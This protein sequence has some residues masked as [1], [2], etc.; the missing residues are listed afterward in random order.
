MPSMR[1]SVRLL[2]GAFA[3]ALFACEGASPDADV[4]AADPVVAQQSAA[5]TLQ[6]LKSVTPT[7]PNPWL[8]LLP[9][10]VKPDYDYWSTYKRAQ[11]A[12]RGVSTVRAAAV[13]QVA[14]SESES[15]NTQGTADPVAG[16]GTA[17]ADPVA[18]L[19]GAIGSAT[20]VDFFSF[21]LRAGDVIS[22]AVASAR[23]LELRAPNGTLLVG[24][25]Q[26]LSFL[27]PP[28]SPLLGNRSSNAGAALAYVV[29]AAGTYALAVRGATGSYA[30]D[31]QVHRPTL[32]ASGTQVVF[33][34]FDG[35]DVDP[36]IFDGP[37]GTRSL[38]PLA[39][40]LPA[41]GLTAAD[42]DAVITAIVNS[43][44]ENLS[45]DL[46]A[47]GLNP[48]AAIDLR[49][50]RD[51]LDP[52]TDAHVSRIIVG[53]TIPE[54]GLET[55]GVAQS[56]DPG[57]FG[58]QETAVV[59]LDILTG[60][61]GQSPLLS[62]LPRASGVSLISLVGTAVGNIVAHEAGHYLGN[63]HTDN[64]NSVANI[65]DQG[66]Y[67][68]N[69][70][71]LGPDGIFGSADDLDVDLGVDTYVPDEE[72]TGAE[73]TL[74]ITAFGSSGQAN[75]GRF[76]FRPSAV[77]NSTLR[78]E[79]RDANLAASSASVTLTA[80]SGDSET[81]TLSQP[82]GQSGFFKASLPTAQGSATPNNGSLQVQNG[83]SITLRYQDAN[84]GA[85]AAVAVTATLAADCQP[86]ASAGVVTRE[87]TDVTARVLFTTAEPATS[88]LD[89][90]TSCSALTQ[91][92]NGPLA[93]SHALALSNLQPDTNY[94]YAITTTD[95]V[96]NATRS[97]S[98]TTCHTFR[99]ASRS[100]T[101]SRNFESDAGGFTALTTA[102]SLSWHRTSA[103]AS[104]LP[105]HS[106]TNSFYFGSDASCTSNS[107][108]FRN[109]GSLTSP[110]F[111]VSANVITKLRFNYLLQT[112]N[113]EL[114]DRAVV[115][116]SVNNGPFKDLA[117]NREG[118]LP[119]T[120]A[121]SWSSA[122]IDLLP[123]LP[124]G[125]SSANLVVRFSFDDV[126]ASQEGYAGF[127]VDD[128]E[129][130]SLGA[131]NECTSS[132]E[133]DDGLFCNGAEACVGGRCTK[134]RPACDDLIGCT[135]DAC[136][137]ATDRCLNTPD[138]YVCLDSTLCDGQEICVPGQ[139]CVSPGPYP[140]AAGLV[141]SNAESA[142]V[143]ACTSSYYLAGFQQGELGEFQTTGSVTEVT[144]SGNILA[145]IAGTGSLTSY[146]LQAALAPALALQYRM[147][148]TGYDAGERI[149]V[150]YCVANCETASSWV[151]LNTVTGSVASTQ[152]S[153]TLP[154]AARTDTL[155]LRWTS[156][157]SSSTT[158]RAR[159]DDIVLRDPTCTAA[160][161]PFTPRAPTISPITIQVNGATGEVLFSGTAADPDNDIHAV[162]VA[163]GGPG[164]P[165]FA[166]RAIGTTNWS[167]RL[168]LAPG[169]YFAQAL[170]TDRRSGQASSE[171]NFTVP[172]PNDPPPPRP[173]FS[174]S[175]E[176]G[177]LSAFT[178]QGVV[179]VN[180]AAGDRPGTTGTQGVQIDD[181]GRIVSRV[182]DAR[183]GTGP[184]T[185][186]YW[187]DVARYDTG[188]AARVAYCAANCTVES[189][190]VVVNTLGGT[191]GWR[192]F[193]HTLPA[194]ARTATLQLR[195]V[196]TADGT[197]EF[198]SVDDI[199]LR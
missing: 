168:F 52:G 108:A 31:L 198:A 32:D 26:D 187:L 40:F 5:L 45:A 152:Y 141:C 78:L 192:S 48:R 15:N 115:S 109:T 134:R 112:R 154:A 132:T 142:C 16:F 91:S 60:A 88:R 86:P 148:V 191:S 122:T 9:A 27:Y 176:S 85:G 38:S 160:L 120:G 143:P 184:L 183:A 129:V 2:V 82:A 166:T 151:T 47:R 67:I 58:T 96:G 90:G 179:A 30:V 199:V 55:I 157:A 147:E 22:A 186:E 180:T 118:N 11:W 68:E 169:A 162:E 137:E 12:T 140:C 182:I 25:A 149:L 117:S 156:N 71:G 131:G 80:S 21:T 70:I 130:V 81:V 188:E 1:S 4:P 8:A 177:G 50:S 124:A 107:E 3:V 106:G 161:P 92:R 69:T 126:A 72:F 196:T 194:T 66:G 193:T 20:D 62:V 75:L 155:Q 197:L 10:G 18:R 171:A 150:Q 110:S 144:V 100:V 159:I 61:A 167:V 46:A 195:W 74:N 189:S 64:A 35:A 185:L 97:P 59:L 102:G 79:L 77:C 49:N 113:N 84:N 34:D 29:N 89:F 101:L 56:I 123:L 173:L 121:S 128:V 119:E 99:T 190:W 41:L 98:A 76:T 133:C 116:V 7:S 103:C 6:T 145:N 125:A 13:A 28:G 178:T 165:F 104:A 164:I 153:H 36:A 181:T 172:N 57:N 135:D 43:T 37:A 39:S 139:G 54:L 14:V 83:A 114:A 73:D 105:G 93:T 44:R 23:P 87:I 127:Y 158:E 53:G 138:I 174:Q 95:A 33:L 136:D 170:V 163:I 65:M 19:T 111:V 146:G 42:Q 94:F 63:Y 175:F 24:S 17:P 51:H